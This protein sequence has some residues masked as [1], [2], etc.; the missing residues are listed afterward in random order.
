MKCEK[1]SSLLKKVVIKKYNYGESGVKNVWLMNIPGLL[2]KNCDQEI[3]IV[4]A[5]L[6]LHEVIAK[7]IV[8]HKTSLLS[9]EEIRFLRTQLRLSQIDFSKKISLT[10]ESLSRIEN[11]KLPVSDDTDRRVRLYYIRHLAEPKR[12]YSLSLDVLDKIISM[13]AI[14][15]ESFKI[16]HIKN[17]WEL[18]KVA[19]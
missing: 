17:H 19:A 4:P 15:S 2:C 18:S 10:P 6:E 5:P 13:K 11:N 7:A 8:L 3:A 9:G 14:H 1:C 16:N 12:S